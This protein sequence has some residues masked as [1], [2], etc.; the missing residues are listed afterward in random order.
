M[1]F[2]ILNN[3]VSHTTLRPGKY[4]IVYFLGISS[5]A[6]DA[7]TD[8]VFDE[9]LSSLGW[10]VNVETHAGWTGN[11]TTSWKIK[12]GRKAERCEENVDASCN[13]SVAP[14][15][16]LL[17]IYNSN[18]VCYRSGAD[19]NTATTGGRFDG[20]QQVLYWADVTSEVAFVFPSPKTYSPRVRRLSASSGSI[21]YYVYIVFFL[22]SRF[23]FSS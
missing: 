8:A 14:P 5:Q 22:F 12:S 17:R 23:F 2:E 13:G 18:V 16:Y 9:F 10:P 15:L 19:T 4:G 1:P 21:Y 7:H 20:L 6:T 3:V 11:V